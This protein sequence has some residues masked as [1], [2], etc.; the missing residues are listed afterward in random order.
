MEDFTLVAHLYA[1]VCLSLSLFKFPNAFLIAS[2][3][4]YQRGR[5]VN[6]RRCPLA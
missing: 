4:N 6:E 2:K 3:S 5:V 1:V